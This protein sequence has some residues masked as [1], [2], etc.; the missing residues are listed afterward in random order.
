MAALL[1][2]MQQGRTVSM[3]VVLALLLLWES[4]HPFFEYFRTRRTDRGLHL[5]RNLLLGGLNALVI[6]VF[7][8]GIWGVTAIWAS[9]N[10]FGLLHWLDRTLGTPSWLRA[11]GAVLGLDLWMYM[12]HRINH[13]IPLLWRF[14]RIHHNDPKMDVTTANRFHTGEI[15]LSSALRI[16]VI[17][18]LGTHLW[19]LVLYEG[20]MFA[21][22][23]FHHA[24]VALPP[25]LDRALRAVVVTPAMHKVHHSR[26]QLET[27]SNYSALFSFWDRI[28]RTFRLR[29][30]LSTLRFGLDG[31]DG[32]EDQSFLGMLRG[33]L[34]EESGS[35]E[36]SSSGTS[37]R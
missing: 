20:L 27:D 15:V 1:D 2:I 37:S 30:D 6:S 32:E 29:E 13:R 18:L 12:W 7:F 5:L 35:G 26:R 17:A 25:W 36:G 31:W 8:V 33:P 23:Q 16:P 19:E 9:E 34:K 24:N 3:L 28:G 22:V 11:A 4:A 21:V 10:G 14:H